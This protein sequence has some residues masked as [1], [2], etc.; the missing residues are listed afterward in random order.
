MKKSKKILSVILALVMVFSSLS[1]AVIAFAAKEDI[2]TDVITKEKVDALIGD[3]NTLLKQKVITGSAFE[4]IYKMLP[5]LKAVVSIEGGTIASDNVKFYQTLYPER[6]EKLSTSD[7]K[8]KADVKDEKGNITEKGTFT[9][10]FEENPIVLK[11]DEQVVAEAE[12]LID[13]VLVDNMCQTLTMAIAFAQANGEPLF[14]GF[15]KVCQSLGIEQ[16]ASLYDLLLTNAAGVRTYFKNIVNA[17]LPNAANGIISILRKVAVKENLGLLYT[18]VSDILNN[19]SAVLTMVNSFMPGV[20]PADIMETINGLVKDFNALPTLDNP[21][22]FNLEKAASLV[23]AN[24]AKVDGDLVFVDDITKAT[25][26]KNFYLEHLDRLL[27]DLGAAK[28]NSE[29]FVIVYNYLFKNVIKNSG[30]MAIIF[31]LVKLPASINPDL[32]ASATS[33]ELFELLYQIAGQATGR[34]EPEVP[35]EPTVPTDPSAPA[36]PTEPAEPSAPSAPATPPSNGD[37]AVI[38]IFAAVAAL[39]CAALV[40]TKKRK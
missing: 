3:T 5:S 21:K 13:M 28:D 4:E 16:S 22:R 18:G 35:E 27:S 7:G 24:Y 30:N 9:L 36:D 19:L 8:I 17:V 1:A 6:F 40:F 20:L 33:D 23:F 25:D 34:I 37:S 2:Y 39:A 15:D 31:K 14:K 11:N 38:G 32:F 12:K 29:A 10:F 26:G